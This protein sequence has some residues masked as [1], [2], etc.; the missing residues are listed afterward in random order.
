MIVENAYPV[1]ILEAVRRPLTSHLAE[2][3]SF[4]KGLQG[5]RP[6]GMT[7]SHTTDSG[8]GTALQFSEAH[9]FEWVPE[10]AL[11][12]ALPLARPQG[13]TFQISYLSELD[14]W[15][16]RTGL[17]EMLLDPAAAVKK[18]LL[19]SCSVLPRVDD[20]AWSW[21]SW[22]PRI[23]F[24]VHPSEVMAGYLLALRGGRV[25]SRPVGRVVEGV[26]PFEPRTGHYIQMVRPAWRGCTS[27][28]FPVTRVI[29]AGALSKQ[30][31][32]LFIHFGLFRECRGCTPVIL[33]EP[34]VP[35]P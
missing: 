14:G 33:A 2:V 1:G 13:R 29:E 11:S 19:P 26:Y 24:V 18:A 5:I 21:G 35:A 27:I 23:G 16:W 3:N 6:F 34:R 9:V 4:V 8:S 7:S 12:A 30:G 15:F 10:L 31:A 28:G 25:A 17:A 32:Y 22:S 20:C